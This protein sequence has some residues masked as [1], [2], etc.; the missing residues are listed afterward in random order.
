MADDTRGDVSGSDTPGGNDSATN[1]RRSAPGGAN[2]ALGRTPG[3][4]ATDQP[5]GH[6]PVNR[7]PD[8]SLPG[9]DDVTGR[10]GPT[11]VAPDTGGDIRR[12]RRRELHPEVDP[13]TRLGLQPTVAAEDLPTPLAEEPTRPGSRVATAALAGV[14]A[15]GVVVLLSFLGGFEF[16]RYLAVE[17]LVSGPGAG[18]PMVL[19]GVAVALG[20]G[21]AWAAL[22]GLLVSRPSALAGAAF[23]LLPAAFNWLVA[24]GLS[25]DGRTSVSLLVWCVAF[26]AVLWGTI[27]G[28]LCRRWLRPP[29]AAATSPVGD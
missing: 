19:L 17:R 25:V 14:I 24:G 16:P 5:A 4:L 6:S 8:E 7:R 18:A 20:L 15:S 13:D 1:V 27:V 26:H 22:F 3:D 9:T 11:K 29:Y 12:G 21:T 2:F 28:H 10:W 23:G